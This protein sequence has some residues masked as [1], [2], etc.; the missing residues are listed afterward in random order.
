MVHIEAIK[1]VFQ[2]AV[3]QMNMSAEQMTL[4]EDQL[5]KGQILKLFPDQKAL[6]Q[7]GQ[8]QLVA[9]LEASINASQSY[10]FRVKGSGSKGLQL[11]IIKQVEEDKFTK[12]SLAKDLL[13]MFQ[14]KPSK[15]NILLAN[16]LVK[17]DIPVTKEQL[18]TA[19]ELLK[20]TPKRDIPTFI[21]AVK[22]AI[23]QQYPLSENVIKSLVQVQT[24]VPLAGQLDLLLQSLQHVDLETG[25]VKKLQQSLI[26]LMRKS[27]D[28]IIDVETL[29]ELQA[30]KEM[31]VA[32]SKEGEAYV[33][34]DQIEPLIHRLNGQ[35]LLQQDLGPT[36]QFI[37]LVP[38]FGIN[39]SDLTIQWNGKRQNDG[40]IDP[41]FCRIIFY[42][43][44]PVLNETM[45][46]VQIQNRVMTINITND[47]ENVRQ[48]VAGNSNI[49]KE[50][51]AKIDYRL[52]LISVKPFDSTSN[53]KITNK[54]LNLTSRNGTYTGV[55]VKI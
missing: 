3:S 53:H 1:N 30:L 18:V 41:A 44:L 9:D 24:N 42:L 31:L 21:S 10:W 27:V 51:L 22:F 38:L 37:T 35:S 29:R 54:Q 28:Q 7:V 32:V 48:F 46:D 23:K 33:L 8:S 39:R 50:L 5:V 52:S 19:L 2:Q 55:D 20:N 15:E 4:K 11:K 40:T 13:S 25:L 12:Q 14:Q 26:Q 16:E 45:V 34:K 17:E 43:Q 49:L 47:H 36:S 6:I